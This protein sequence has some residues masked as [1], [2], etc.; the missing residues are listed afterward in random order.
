[1]AFFHFRRAR[2]N[3]RLTNVAREKLRRPEA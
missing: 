2:L 1:M 3:E